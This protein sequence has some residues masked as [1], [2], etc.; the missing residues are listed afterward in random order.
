MGVRSL[1]SYDYMDNS[2]TKIRKNIKEEEVEEDLP[3]Y[4]SGFPVI[5]IKREARL[6]Y[7]SGGGGGV[8][9]EHILCHLAQCACIKYSL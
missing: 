1:K 6:F 4:E 7:Y 2:I 5:I 9:V 3:L 8:I